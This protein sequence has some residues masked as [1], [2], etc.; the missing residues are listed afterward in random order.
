MEQI[1]SPPLRHLPNSKGRKGGSL[2][3]RQKA[4]GNQREF[5]HGLRCQGDRGQSSGSLGEGAS[6]ITAGPDLKTLEGRACIIRAPTQLG[7]LLLFSC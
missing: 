4:S 3:L 2:K 7:L 5:S 6:A 1:V